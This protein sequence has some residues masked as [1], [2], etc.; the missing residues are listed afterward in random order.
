MR[1]ETVEKLYKHYSDL[2]DKLTDAQMALSA[3][4]GVK[5][6]T[7]GDRSLTRRDLGEIDKMLEDAIK[8]MEEYENLLNGKP[9]RALVG[10]IPTDF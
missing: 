2:V 7:I 10:V 3:D 6:Y 5:A 9:L 4:G 8:K 1:R